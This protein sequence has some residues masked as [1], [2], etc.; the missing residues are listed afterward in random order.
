MAFAGRLFC[1]LSDDT[2][3]H[4]GLEARIASAIAPT[5]TAM[6]Y[7]LVRVQIQG[8][9][10]PTVQVMADRADGS[11]IGVKDCEAISHA[12]GAVLDVDDPFPG[13]WNLEVSSAG[14]D[15]P[16]TRTKDWIR[17]AS[18]V[19]TVEMVV[20]QDGRRRF[21]GRILSAD[22]NE[23]RLK[24]DEG[25]EITLPRGNIRRAKLVLTDELIA[26]TAQP[27]SEGED[28]EAAPRKAPKRWRPPSERN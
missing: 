3:Q 11:L 26:A 13:V 21:R 9:E 12:V 10:R 15:R 23:V 20:P 7:E 28:A 18:Q 4:E 8:K 17:F 16:L 24:L 2:P 1:F 14:I 5:L 27:E 6:G 19:A 25:G 22:E